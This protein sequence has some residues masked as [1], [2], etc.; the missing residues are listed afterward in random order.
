M[1]QDLYHRSIIIPYTNKVHRGMLSFIT[2]IY[3]VITLA[4]CRQASKRMCIGALNTF[5]LACIDRSKRVNEK[6][7]KYDVAQ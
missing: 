1:F 7:K 6:H 5:N 4:Y 3:F 2:M